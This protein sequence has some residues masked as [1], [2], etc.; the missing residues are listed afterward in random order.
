MGTG[1]RAIGEGGDREVNSYEG[2]GG[3]EGP[4]RYK[5]R[6]ERGPLHSSLGGTRERNGWMVRAEARAHAVTVVVVR[7]VGGSEI[8]ARLVE[9]TRLGWIWRRR[10]ATTTNHDALAL[11]SQFG[12]M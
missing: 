3:E 2:E 9:G 11:S 1:R 10:T 4:G 12:L 5:R 7:I 6:L 8:R